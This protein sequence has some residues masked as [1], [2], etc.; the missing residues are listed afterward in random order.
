MQVH[1]LEIGLNIQTPFC[2]NVLLKSL[3]AYKNHGFNK[4]RLIGAG[5]GKDIYLQQYGLKIYNKSLQ[6]SKIGNILRIEKK[7]NKMICLGYGKV[8]LEDLKKMEFA[9]YCL[10]NLIETFNDVIIV[11]QVDEKHLSKTELKTYNFCSNPRNWETMSKKK[12]C[13]YR[14]LIAEIIQKQ[15][16]TNLKSTTLNLLALKGEELLHS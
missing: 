1:H 12:R 11:D 6:Y 13:R 16:A 8:Y 4:M 9:K 10:S 5:A 2:L 3:V 15:T 7:I 14:S